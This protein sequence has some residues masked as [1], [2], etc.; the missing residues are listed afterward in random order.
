LL[1]SQVEVVAGCKDFLHSRRKIGAPTFEI[2]KVSTN[3]ELDMGLA[4]IVAVQKSRRD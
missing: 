4:A 3:F 2:E 1:V